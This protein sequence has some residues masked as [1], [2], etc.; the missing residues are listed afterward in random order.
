M[1]KFRVVKNVLIKYEYMVL[2]KKVDQF[3]VKYYLHEE[4]I[5]PSFNDLSL[6]RVFNI[7]GDQGWELAVKENDDTYI[8]KRQRKEVKYDY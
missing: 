5:L 2:I 4:A 8:L 1:L 6:I 3:G 7:L